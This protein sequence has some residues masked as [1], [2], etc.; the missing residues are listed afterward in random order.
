MDC[1]NLSSTGLQD[2]DANDVIADNIT[3]LSNLNVNGSTYLYNSLNVQGVNILNSINNLNNII[4][5]N[6]STVHINA[7]NL[8]NFNVNNTQLTKIDT[9][10]LSIFHDALG[11][12]PYNYEGW[13]NIGDRFNKLY[14]VM[15]DSPNAIINYDTTHNTIIR[16]S[17]QDTVNQIYYPRQLQ[18]QSYQGTAF[19]KFDIQGLQL[20]DKNNNWY[21]IN[22]IFTKTGNSMLLASDNII[23]DGTGQLNVQ[24]VVT[25]YV[26]GIATGTTG[27]WFSV[28]DSIINSISG[29]SALTSGVS[30]L[31]TKTDNILANIASIAGS[32]SNIAS[33]ANYYSGLQS[34]IAVTNGVVSTTG[35]MLAF[36]L[37]QD[38]FDAKF[39]LSIRDP[40]A[41]ATTSQEYLKQLELNYN[42]TLLN[43]NNKLSINTTGFLCPYYGDLSLISTPSDEPSTSTNYVVVITK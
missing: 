28:K 16:I 34:S 18:I 42:A 1:Y 32:A 12:F 41:P 22:K 37:K 23:V 8:I 29:V 4:N 9:T 43:V 33:V 21:Y 39:P 40:I 11:T 36:D 14:H 17:E 2:I 31:T 35:L 30:S 20:L 24:N 15:S 5:N 27:T 19:S 25:N 26:L 7:S 3:I 10:G 38:R 6:S 13:Y